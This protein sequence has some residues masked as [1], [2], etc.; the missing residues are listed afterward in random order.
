MFANAKQAEVLALAVDV[1]ELLG[2][3]AQ[4][5]DRHSTSVDA[6]N[7]SPGTAQ[8]ARQPERVRGIA[9]EPFALE[10]RANR[11]LQRWRQDEHTLNRHSSA[12]WRKD[13]VSARSPSMGVTAS[14]KMDLPAPVSPVR[15]LKRGSSVRWSSS[16]MAKS[17]MCSSRN[18]VGAAPC[19]SLSA[20]VRSAALL[21]RI[22]RNGK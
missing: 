17:S 9:F 15:M 18:T 11:G 22:S 19:R 5:R 8:F 14:I 12:P 2:D 10:D 21:P 6:G 4:Q 20:I 7:G 3:F 16:M 1:N 13:V